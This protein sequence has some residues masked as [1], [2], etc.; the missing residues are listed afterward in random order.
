MRAEMRRVVVLVAAAA[1]LAL[2]GLARAGKAVFADTLPRNGAT[3]VSFTVQRPAAFRILLRTSTLGRTRLY[4]LGAHAPKGGPLIDTKTARCDGAA[5]SW[6]CRGSYEPLPAGTYT[7]RIVFSSSVPQS[8]G[9][10][11]L[12]VRW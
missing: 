1:A 5:G 4:L 8:P 11:E 9:G 3:G 7:F 2:P 6:Y 12:T 10:F